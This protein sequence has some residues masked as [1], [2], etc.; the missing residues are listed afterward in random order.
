MDIFNILIAWLSCK[1]HFLF[2]MDTSETIAA[3]ATAT[4]TIT[5]YRSVDDIIVTILAV[6]VNDMLDPFMLILPVRL[7]PLKHDGKCTAYEYVPL[8]RENERFFNNPVRQSWM[9]I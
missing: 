7:F 5:I 2:L 3:A 9:S 8:V 6:F 4:I 1:E